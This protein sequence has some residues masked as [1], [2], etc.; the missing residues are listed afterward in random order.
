M[1]RKIATACPLPVAGPNQPRQILQILQI[2]L[3][4]QLL[5]EIFPV[6]AAHGPSGRI[7]E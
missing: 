7:D 2:R 5:P 4:A 1:Q 3:A 6:R